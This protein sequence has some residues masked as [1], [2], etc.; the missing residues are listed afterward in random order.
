MVEFYLLFSVSLCLDEFCAWVLK[1]QVVDLKDAARKYFTL[2]QTLSQIYIRL[3]YVLCIFIQ[4]F[5][6]TSV[7]T[8]HL[9]W[10]LGATWRLSSCR[11]VRWDQ[12]HR[13]LHITFKYFQYSASLIG[14]KMFSDALPLVWQGPDEPGAGTEGRSDSCVSLD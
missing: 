10:Q 9:K 4:D 7:F 12:L 5:D 6:E 2:F 13:S 3:L 14:Q 1:L 8:K 11:I